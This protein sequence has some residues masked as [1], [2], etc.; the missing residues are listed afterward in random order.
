MAA[1]RTSR[2]TRLSM[3]Y[4]VSSLMTGIKS[5]VSGATVVS[6]LIVQWPACASPFTRCGKQQ[7]AR[8]LS[9]AVLAS[10]RR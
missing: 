10:R 4:M 8:T 6:T 3:R 1:P 2:R 5:A 9:D 7:K